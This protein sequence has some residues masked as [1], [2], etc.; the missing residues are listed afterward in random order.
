LHTAGRARGRSLCKSAQTPAAGPATIVEQIQEDSMITVR[1]LALASLGAAL[2]A[3]PVS[4]QSL[5][6]Y[7]AYSLGSTVTSVV[8][9]SGARASDLKTLHQRP[10]RIQEI[11]WRAPFVTSGTAAAD[12]VRNVL[13]SFYDDQ[14]YRI[15]VTYERDRMEGLTNADVV[16]SVSAAYSALPMLARAPADRLPQDMPT[17][18]T[19]VA[20][21]DDGA[22]L[23]TLVRGHYSNQF[24]LV[25][26]SKQRGAQARAAIGESIR[27]DAEDAPQREA[28][29]RAKQI[30]EARTTQEKARGVNKAAFRP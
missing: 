22:S 26:M 17:D 1:V 25:L 8:T 9:T 3:Q 18:T 5:S 12:P 2:A 7:R 19:V 15:V 4:G 30:V 6:R 11:E 29:R 13:F 20:Q 24:Q 10:A 27:L 23:L 21:W 14:L 28:D 16:D